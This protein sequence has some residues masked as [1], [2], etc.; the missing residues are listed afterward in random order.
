MSPTAPDLAIRMATPADDGTLAELGRRTFT[1]T[2]AHDNTPQDMAAFLGAT[3]G[4]ELQRREIDDPA[5]AVLVAERD[6]RP[7]AYAML[8][9]GEAPACVTGPEPIE[10]ARFYVDRAGHGQGIA[11]RLMARVLET[12]AARGA[13]T[14]WLGV[15]ERNARAIAFY[16]KQGFEDVGSHDFVLGSDVQTDRLMQRPVP[17]PAR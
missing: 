16:R 12:A 13:R 7:V 8:R 3:F 14:L 2:F 4:P 15:W 10:L 11:P 5:V 9:E 17:A 6:A 1:D